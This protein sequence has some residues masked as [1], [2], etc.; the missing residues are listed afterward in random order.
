M[1]K[2]KWALSLLS[3]A[4]W[5]WDQK[6]PIAPLCFFVI[7]WCFSDAK[8]CYKPDYSESC[9]V[10]DYNV[11]NVSAFQTLIPAPA[12][13]DQSRWG[14]MF[15]CR[16]HLWELLTKST[17]WIY[18]LNL[19]NGSQ[20]YKYQVWHAQTS[21]TTY[22][23]K[24]FGYHCTPFFGKLEKIYSSYVHLGYCRRCYAPL[25]PVPTNWVQDL[26]TKFTLLLPIY[27]DL[28]LH[29]RWS[30]KVSSASWVSPPYHSFLC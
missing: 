19:Q 25:P 18:I 15:W 16:V 23:T 28:L 21:R 4:W 3:G 1:A 11:Y 27:L 26:I 10:S 7:C 5:I 12:N 2:T 6:E 24:S 20:I 17:D 30:L 22:S 9:H 14:D 13:W 8:R 29:N